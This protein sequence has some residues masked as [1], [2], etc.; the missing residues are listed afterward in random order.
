MT[1]PQIKNLEKVATILAGVPERFVFTRG[2]TIILYIDEIVRDELRPTK[3]IDCVLK[4]TASHIV[5]IFSRTEYYRLATALREV[6]LSE[7]FYW[8]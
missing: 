8:R 3:D 2:G 7:F 1:N 6:G 4:N 5:E